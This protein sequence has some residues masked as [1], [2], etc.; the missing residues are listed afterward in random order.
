[1]HEGDPAAIKA[2]RGR[3]ALRSATES[4]VRLARSWFVLIVVLSTSASGA[5]TQ[6]ELSISWSRAALPPQA[7]AERDMRVVVGCGSVVQGAAAHACD[8]PTRR[9]D[10]EG[11]RQGLARRPRK[12]GQTGGPDCAGT[13]PGMAGDRDRRGADA[14]KRGVVIRFAFQKRC[15][16]QL[17]D[18]QFSCRSGDCPDAQGN[19][20][21]RSGHQLI[22]RMKA[23]RAHRTS[24]AALLFFSS[25]PAV[26]S[27]HAARLR[28]RYP[29]IARRA[30]VRRGT[31]GR[32]GVCLSATAKFLR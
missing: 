2:A 16:R 23:H 28:L 8:R 13:G 7:V 22:A 15:A 18:I 21:L 29:S 24:G 12:F 4:V 5:S 6:A 14:G 1:M 10:E 25:S 32:E 27:G 3:A 30:P 11:C 9:L 31:I 20:Y 17:C 26:A 19:R